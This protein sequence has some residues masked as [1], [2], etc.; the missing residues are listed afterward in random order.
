LK[1]PG[2]QS[3]HLI[4]SLSQVAQFKTEHLAQTPFNGVLPS[5]HMFIQVPLIILNPCLHSVQAVVLQ[6]AHF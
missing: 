4:K 2:K 5:G 1:N 6:E 3:I